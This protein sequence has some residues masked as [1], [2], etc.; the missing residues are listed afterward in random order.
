MNVH[1]DDLDKNEIEDIIG[2]NKPEE[3][4]TDDDNHPM[5]SNPDEPIGIFVKHN[6]QYG[7][8]KLVARDQDRLEIEYFYASVSENVLPSGLRN[9]M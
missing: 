7:I 3:I 8:G 9:R 5:I 6:P 1:I 4:E 2:I